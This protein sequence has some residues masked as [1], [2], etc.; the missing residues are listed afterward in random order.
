LTKP[1]RRVAAAAAA[2][3]ALGAGSAIWASTSASAAP[4]TP[5]VNT[6]LLP[7]C[8]ADDLSVWVNYGAAQGA[9]GTWYYPLEFTNTSNHTCRTWGWP[10]VSATNG[11]GDQLGDSAQRLTLYAPHWVNIGAGE[12]AHALFSYGAAEVSTSGCKPA[13]ASMIKVYPPNQFAADYGFFSLPA[14]TVGG[15][16]SYLRVAAIEPGA[17]I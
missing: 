13:N 8:T 16:H 17:N 4:T 12:T 1:F 10:G 6:G 2:A 7:V 9:A 5:S 3:L 11:N 15:G 14:C